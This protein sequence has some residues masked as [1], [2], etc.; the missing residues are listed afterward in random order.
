MKFNELSHTR[1]GSQRSAR[2]ANG[3]GGEGAKR[4]NTYRSDFI[5]ILHPIVVRQGTNEKAN[6]RLFVLASSTGLALGAGVIENWKTG[7]RKKK[8]NVRE[9]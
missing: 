2:R 6:L 4:G 8:E 5:P 9:L 1:S 7:G 3:A